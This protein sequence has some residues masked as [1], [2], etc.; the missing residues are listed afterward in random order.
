MTL[1]QGIV[2]AT[3]ILAVSAAVT[4][5][6]AARR[7]PYGLRVQCG[8]RAALAATYVVAYIWLLAHMVQ[9]ARWSQTVS[10]LSLVTWIAVWNMPAIIALRLQSRAEEVADG[11]A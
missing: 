11:E 5:F 8:V 7:G 10:G 4:N 2:I 1:D 9:R 6:V 3:T